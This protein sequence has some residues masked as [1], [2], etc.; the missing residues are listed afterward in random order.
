MAEAAD[1]V[2]LKID[3]LTHVEMLRMNLEVCFS[4]KGRLLP[5]E[6]PVAGH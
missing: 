1:K 5:T 6:H 3:V 4:T 2:D